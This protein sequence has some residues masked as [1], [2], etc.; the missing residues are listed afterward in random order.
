MNSVL[1]ET[2]TRVVNSKGSFSSATDQRQT[3]MQTEGGRRVYSPS[4]E[5]ISNKFRLSA[6]SRP[7]PPL[8][9]R[10]RRGPFKV[11]FLSCSTQSTCEYS[12]RETSHLLMMGVSL[13]SFLQSSCD[14]SVFPAPKATQNDSSFEQHLFFNRCYI[15]ETI[16]KL[17]F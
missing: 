2:T 9:R 13:G 4:R 8:S 10:R 6:P 14:I 1:M 12:Q 11:T 3:D 5:Q 7:P 15:Q 16:C 17:R